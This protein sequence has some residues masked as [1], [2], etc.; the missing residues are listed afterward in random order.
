MLVKFSGIDERDSTQALRGKYLFA[1]SDQEQAPE[2]GYWEHQLV[3]LEVV[4][5][6]GRQLGRITEAIVREAQDLWVI[7]HED[8]TTMLPAVPAFIKNVDLEKGVVVI[9]P[10]AGLFPE[11]NP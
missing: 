2:G 6:T 3:G 5:V 10:P 8:T 11:A 9:D 7:T 1:P 4:D